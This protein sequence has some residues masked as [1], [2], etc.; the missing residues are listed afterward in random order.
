M[1]YMDQIYLSMKERINNLR[2]I[3][4]VKA[5]FNYLGGCQRF[6]LHKLELIQFLQEEF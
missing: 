4:R 6:L 5:V 1:D 3:Q 2:L